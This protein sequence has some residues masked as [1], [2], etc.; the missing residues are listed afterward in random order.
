MLQWL[1]VDDEISV[2]CCDFCV[3]LFVVFVVVIVRV[4][5]NTVTFFDLKKKLLFSFGPDGT[6]LRKLKTVPVLYTV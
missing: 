1:I 6:V 4:S 3:V 5:N 2:V